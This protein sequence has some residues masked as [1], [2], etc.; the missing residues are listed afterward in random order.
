MNF[1]EL[2][3]AEEIAS[4]IERNN[5]SRKFVALDFETTGLD[6]WTDKIT[7]IVMTGED[8]DSVV[9]FSAQFLPLLGKIKCDT[10]WQNF[11]YDFK[12]ANKSH[13]VDLR[14]LPGKVWDTMLLDHLVDENNDHGLDAIVQR[15]YQDNYKEVFWDK[16]KEFADAPKDAQVEYM[17]KDVY[18]TNLIY[19]ESLLD[20]ADQSMTQDTIN[21][22]HQLAMALYA[23]EVD[24]VLIDLNYVAEAGLE[25]KTSIENTLKEMRESCAIECAQIELKMWEREMDKRKTAK[26]KAAVPRPEFNFNSAK[27]VCELIYDVLKLPVQKNPKTK[28][29]SKDDKA[30]SKIAHLHP[31]VANLQ[32]LS[33]YEKMYGTFVQGVLERVRDG[34]IYPS[35]HVNGT[36]TGRISASD[37]NLQQLPAK[38]EWAKL[39]GMFIPP[40]GRK[41][42]CADY[43]QLEICLAAHYSEDPLLL[44]MVRNN[45]SM[46]DYTAKATGLTR[47]QA[48][49]MNFTVLYGGTEYKVAEDLKCTTEEA[50]K[51]LDLLMQSYRGLGRLINECHRMAKHGKPIINL[52]GRIRHF[53]GNYEQA[54]DMKRAQRQSFN[55]LIQGTGADFT[56]RAF[57][58]VSALMRDRGWGRA[59]F[60]IHDEIVVEAKEEYCAQVSDMLKLVMEGLA[61][62]YDLR[63]PL[64]A[65][66]SEPKD[67]WSK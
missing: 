61:Q 66:V 36:V 21:F 51:Y 26:G 12:I 6:H 46:H 13:G 56:H 55:S 47:D 67:R 32:K 42:I 38:D 49:K 11:K 1:K 19:R 65:E 62:K 14:E 9:F 17:C 50:K 57:V 37:P 3:T 41:I 2:T 29:R 40:P 15:R 28:S 27:Q 25:L 43:S 63:V 18:Y 30:L 8:D 20:L 4:L 33:K 7:D 52:F 54:W 44:K 34:R 10:V 45:E 31:V 64:R 60:P 23:T 5:R 59:L 39:R 35:F 22:V 48:K 16:Y 24:G 58:Q 53:S